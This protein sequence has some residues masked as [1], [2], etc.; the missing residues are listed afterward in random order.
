M[1]FLKKLLRRADV[2]QN[3]RK[4]AQIKLIGCQQSRLELALVHFSSFKALARA[5]A[6]CRRVFN[7]SHFPILR[8]SEFQEIAIAAAHFEQT[9]C[10]IASITHDFREI[11]PPRSLFNLAGITLSFL[12]LAP[13]KILCTVNLAQLFVAW[14]G[15]EKDESAI[16]TPYDAMSRC[17]KQVVDPRSFAN[18]AGFDH[19][20]RVRLRVHSGHF[21]FSAV[22]C[23]ALFVTRCFRKSTANK[24]I[25]A[26]QASPKS[27]QLNHQ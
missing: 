24:M 18:V 5:V 26:V 10:L 14:L 9:P 8:F 7:S 2:L 3:I 12:R 15:I 1:D 25:I 4:Y 22:N 16:I 11:F 6:C 20:P 27:T 21:P 17:R 23:P 13:K 19:R